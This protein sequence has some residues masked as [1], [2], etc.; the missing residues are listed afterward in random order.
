[1][2]SATP[3]RILEL[4]LLLLGIFVLSSLLGRLDLEIV[5]GEHQLH[6]CVEVLRKLKVLVSFVRATFS[7][8][9]HLFSR[10]IFCEAIVAA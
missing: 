6:L 5:I 4:D 10:V 8:V 7:S 1:M 9:L 3:D 2:L